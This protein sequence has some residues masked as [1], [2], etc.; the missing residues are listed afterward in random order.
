MAITRGNNKAF[1]ADSSGDLFC[2]ILA[3]LFLTQAVWNVRLAAVQCWNIHSIGVVTVPGVRSLCPKVLCNE[4]I[5]LK[6]AV[7]SESLAFE[8][9]FTLCQAQWEQITPFQG[10]PT[11]YHSMQWGE[12]SCQQLSLETPHLCCNLWCSWESHKL[13]SGC[14]ISPPQDF[15]VLPFD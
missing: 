14:L 10:H 15:P 5:R 8:N 11:P 7:C 2:I 6:S 9:V 3:E 13:C 12:V 1:A 4:F